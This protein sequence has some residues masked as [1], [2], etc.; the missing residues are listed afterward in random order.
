M[1]YCETDFNFI[2][3]L[4]E[5][6]GYSYFFHHKDNCDTMVITD[7]V[8][9]NYSVSYWDGVDEYSYSTTEQG[10]VDIWNETDAISKL[11]LL[12]N[13]SFSHHS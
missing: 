11:A 13:P 12:Q 9:K 6:E 5:A 3:R 1:Q 10:Q 8:D 4:L 2:S 7:K